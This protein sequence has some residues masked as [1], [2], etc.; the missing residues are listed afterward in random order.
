MR[1][2]FCLASS[3]GV[4][5]YKTAFL[6][7]HSSRLRSVSLYSQAPLFCLPPHLFL[8]HHRRDPHHLLCFSRWS[9]RLRRSGYRPTAAFKNAPSRW[10]QRKVPPYTL[11]TLRSTGGAAYFSYN[12]YVISLSS[13][14]VLTFFFVLGLKYLWWLLKE[15]LERTSIVLETI[16]NKTDA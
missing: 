1:C 6:R 12:R 11:R 10:D 3:N 16:D 8:Y 9:A 5:S 15:P 2:I 4:T 14:W 7:A 13:A